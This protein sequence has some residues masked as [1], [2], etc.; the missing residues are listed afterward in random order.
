MATE[1]KPTALNAVFEL[2]ALIEAL[3]L[4][5][6]WRLAKKNQTG[7]GQ[8][9]MVLPGF[10]TS[11]SATFVMRNF[12]RMKGFEPLPWEHGRNPGLQ[13]EIFEA[14]LLQIDQHYAQYGQKISLV[15]WSLGGLYARAIAHKRADKIK[16]VIT[17]GSP[18]GVSSNINA[19]DVD[20]SENVVKLYEKLNPNLDTDPLVNGEPFWQEI[21]PVP[22]TS[23]YSKSD[24]V[25]SWQYCVDSIETS[26]NENIGIFASHLGLTH[27]AQVFHLV[28]NRLEQDEKNWKP[29]VVKDEAKRWFFKAS[30]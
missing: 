6:Y 12:L 2:R 8:P 26:F 25:T 17:L 13:H 7:D 27:N 1:H 3:A 28:A 16:Q 9:V 11:D 21:P 4:V 19:S 14:L 5:P 23:I 18:F 15:G 30:M 22:T 29:Y 20:V 24:G 10:M